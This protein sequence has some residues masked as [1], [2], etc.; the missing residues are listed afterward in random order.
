[1]AKTGDLFPEEGQIDPSSSFYVHWRKYF[2]GNNEW[3]EIPKNIKYLNEEIMIAALS[4]KIINT[5][6]KYIKKINYSL[7]ERA[8]LE[9]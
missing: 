9:A 1:M 5:K 3:F 2:H 7:K 6:D 4:G 8:D